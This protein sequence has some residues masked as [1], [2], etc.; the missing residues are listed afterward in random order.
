MVKRKKTS[1]FKVRVTEKMKAEVAALAEF[2]GCDES[3]IVR[4]AV[5]HYLRS[6]ATDSEVAK[7]FQQMRGYLTPPTPSPRLNETNSAPPDDPVADALRHATQAAAHQ[8][9]QNPPTPAPASEESPPS[10]AADP[11]TNDPR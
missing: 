1:N 3:D 11:P 8:A 4:E 9:S 5:N 7:L 10:P 6:A 2:R